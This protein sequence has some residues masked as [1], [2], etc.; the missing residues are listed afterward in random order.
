MVNSEV[1]VI[2]VG[3]KL[4]LCIV[5]FGVC[6]LNATRCFAWLCGCCLRYICAWWV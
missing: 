4:R 3:D 2:G 1:F 5:R 6:C